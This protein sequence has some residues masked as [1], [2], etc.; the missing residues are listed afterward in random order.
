MKRFYPLLREI[1]FPELGFDRDICER[2]TQA[3]AGPFI[4][5]GRIIVVRS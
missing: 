5:D 1:V 4:G 2:E 3:A